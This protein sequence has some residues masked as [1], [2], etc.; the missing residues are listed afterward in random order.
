M[1]Q[2]RAN[3]GDGFEAATQR[4]LTRSIGLRP[5]VA[6]SPARGEDSAAQILSFDNI[7]SG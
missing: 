4:P 7:Q 1:A 6:S 3:D 2:I 5:Y